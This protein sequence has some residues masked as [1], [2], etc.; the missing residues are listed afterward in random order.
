MAIDPISSAV[1]RAALLST[2]REVFRRFERTA[3]HPVIY[4]VHDFSVSIF[5]DRVDLIA[6]SSGL[7]EFVGSLAFAVEHL[8]GF[9]AAEGAAP[10]DVAIANDPFETGAHPPDMAVVAPAVADGTLVGFCAIRAHMGDLGAKDSY[11]CDSRSV[12]EEGL[13]FPAIKIATGGVPVEGIYRILAAN[14]RS[15]RETVG[16]LRS[17]VGAAAA[18][19]RRMVEVATTHGLESYRAAVAELLDRGEHDVRTALERIPDGEYRS[20]G[21]LELEGDGAEAVPLRCS[22]RVDGSDITVDVSDSG[23]PQDGPFNVVL[24]Q[25]VAACRLALKRL[26]TQDGLTANSGEYRPLS[27]IAPENS[28]FHAVTP[29]PTFM[30]HSAASLLSELVVTALTPALPDVIP[31]PSSGHTTGFV[32]GFDFDGSYVEVDDLAPIG[33]G[34]TASEDGADALQHFCIAGLS[35]AE[36]EPQ[37]A[38]A[39]VVKESMELV[40]DSGGAGRRRGGLG[41]SVAWRFEIDARVNIQ[42]QKVAKR[43]GGGLAGGSA[44]DGPNA[45]EVRSPDGSVRSFGMTSDLLVRRGDVVVMNGAGGGGYGDP[46]EREPERVREDVRNGFVSVG[47]AERSYGVVIDPGS[48]ELREDD[49]LQER[50]RRSEEATAGVGV[51]A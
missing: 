28:L 41:A 35:L 7:P 21:W 4:D 48:F 31:A 2:S 33:Y 6:D 43:Q 13:V 39:P 45:V 50:A 30:M 3:L 11:P 37:E 36:A 8:A 44:G 9:F 5:D 47:A 20:A 26:T 49:T 46:L 34:A 22:V 27:V 38:R 42:A 32:T 14:S 16:N 25:T 18:G 51:P 23:G 17:A 29:A 40:I 24:P 1:V 19:S 12:Y 10:G 15:P